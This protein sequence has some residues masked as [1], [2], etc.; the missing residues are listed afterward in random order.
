MSA[1][2]FP[3]LGH[4][5]PRATTIAKIGVSQV[6]VFHQPGGSAVG[7]IVVVAMK[8]VTKRADRHVVGV[9]HIVADR[10]QAGAIRVHSHSHATYPD[11]P[12]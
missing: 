7:G 10:C 9:A 8:H 5:L 1:G 3:R 11:M 6:A 2:F 12:V 4:L